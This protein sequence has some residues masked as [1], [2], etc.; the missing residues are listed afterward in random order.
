MDELGVLHTRRNI[1]EA[2][3]KIMSWWVL[4]AI[5]TPRSLAIWWFGRL[6]IVYDVGNFWLMDKW[7]LLDE[8]K[9]KSGEDSLLKGY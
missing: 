4:S 7:Q 2:I 8:L 6:L 5:V 1:L 3:L 9:C